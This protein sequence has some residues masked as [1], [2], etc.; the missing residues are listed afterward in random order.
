VRGGSLL[1]C[2]ENC[3]TNAPFS[4]L[5]KPSCLLAE[6]S[7]PDTT[8]PSLRVPREAVTRARASYRSNSRS[9]S[10]LAIRADV[11]S[12]TSAEQRD[13]RREAKRKGE[14]RRAQKTRIWLEAK[15]EASS[16]R[17][18]QRWQLVPISYLL[19]IGLQE[20][21]EFSSTNGMKQAV[22]PHSAASWEANSPRKFAVILPNTAA[23]FKIRLALPRSPYKRLQSST[24]VVYNTRVII[25]EREREASPIAAPSSD[26]PPKSK[27]PFF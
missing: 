14:R 18:D 1:A 23:R 15:R 20:G 4:R 17:T 27:D 25:A 10:P 26:S 11:G 21:T 9:D 13:M 3:Y 22:P 12:E 16:A 19:V 2:S 24:T 5:R 6:S 7:T 8:S